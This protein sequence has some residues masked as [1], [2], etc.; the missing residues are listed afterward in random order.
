MS[1]GDRS[2]KRARVTLKFE[3][4][5][6]ALPGERPPDAPDL[7]GELQLPDSEEI[8]AAE[9]SEAAT[10]EEES[11]GRDAW[12]RQ[13]RSVTPPPMTAYEPPEVVPPALPMVGDALTLVENRSRE[14]VPAVDPAAEM[15]DRFALD[16]F[17][18]ALR[19]AELILGND[20]GHQEA[21]DTA[22]ACKKKLVR[23]FSSRLGPMSRVP[24]PAVT[25]SE[26][27][28]LGLDHRDGF[29][30]AQVDGAHTIEEIIDVS[31]MPKLAVLK[32]LVELLDMGAIRFSF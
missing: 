26:V 18:A 16:D 5:P 17:T 6:L 8:E 27:R 3:S 29:I 20:P 10:P 31:G 32:T 22:K 28:W 21:L 2:K 12:E 7:S 15:R 11:G 30:L 4:P 25:G 23:I 19:L 9:A 24:E 14:S 13:R 1:E